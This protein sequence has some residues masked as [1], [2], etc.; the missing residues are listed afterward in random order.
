MASVH[1]Q[2]L[3]RFVPVQGNHGALVSVKQKRSITPVG[4]GEEPMKIKEEPEATGPG[5]APVDR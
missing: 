4:E 5:D 3:Y 1:Y 2:I